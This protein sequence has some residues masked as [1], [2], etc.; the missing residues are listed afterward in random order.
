VANL[1]CSPSDD[2]GQQWRLV[3]AGQ[4]GPSSAS[5]SAIFGA[6]PAKLKAPVWASIFG[7][8]P[9]AVDLAPE[10]RQQ[11]GDGKGRR[12]GFELGVIKI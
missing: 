12:Q 10:S 2:S 9:R 4:F 3:L 7:E 8:T 11:S 6:P 5:M 1:F